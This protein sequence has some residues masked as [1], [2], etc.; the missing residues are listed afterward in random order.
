[1]ERFRALTNRP[2]QTPDRLLMLNA[3]LALA[4]SCLVS[5]EPD[6]AREELRGAA[7]EAPD[8][9]Q[10]ARID[11]Y[12]A[13]LALH[14]GRLEDAKRLARHVGQRA[15]D[16]DEAF[17]AQLL[18]ADL[19]A[20]EGSFEA[21][22]GHLQ[23][24]I[25]SFDRLPIARRGALSVR[26]G[27]LARLAGAYAIAIRWYETAWSLVPSQQGELDY[28]IASCYEEGGDWMAAAN[29]YQAIRQPPWSIRGRLAAAKLMERAD[30]WQ[31]AMRLYQSVIQQSVPEAK[32]AQERLGALRTLAATD[33]SSGTAP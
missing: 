27:H 22:L 6:T 20:G 19:S 8:S 2:L 28:R 15:A 23:P 24:L 5:G 7:Q 11:Y 13:L 12:L 16:S 21:A 17:E 26:L 29:R 14:D 31:E 32:I 9:R 25:D 3:R 10:A 4:L 18:L 30:K 33:P 1:M